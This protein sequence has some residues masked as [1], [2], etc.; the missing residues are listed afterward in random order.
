[1]STDSS[2]SSDGTGRSDFTNRRF[3]ISLV[4]LTDSLTFSRRDMGYRRARR[5]EVLA[6]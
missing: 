5:F 2:S 6:C 4:N 3:A 1:M